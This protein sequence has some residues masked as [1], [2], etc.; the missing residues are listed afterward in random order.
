M[1]RSVHTFYQA[2]GDVAQAHQDSAAE[3]LQTW[4]GLCRDL[5]PQGD[6][7]SEDVLQPLQV[8][9]GADRLVVG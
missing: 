4:E 5:E 2:G 8:R 9:A 7:F 6:K 3:A 1:C